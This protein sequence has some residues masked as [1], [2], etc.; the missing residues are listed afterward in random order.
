[1]Q[2]ISGTPHLESRQLEDERVL[3]DITC[4]QVENYLK[5]VEA[6]WLRVT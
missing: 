4:W 5:T 6:Y 1:M 3:F 2:C